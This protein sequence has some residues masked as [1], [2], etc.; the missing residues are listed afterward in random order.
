[1]AII[2]TVNESLFLHAFELAG[3]YDQMGG[4]AGLVAMFE[5][6]DSLSDDMGKNIELDPVAICCDYCTYTDRAE[7]ASD[8]GVEDP[9]DLDERTTVIEYEGG[10]IVQAF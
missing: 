6:L 10:I 8:Y 4:R 2:Q 3:R 5:H 1:M 7:A 9:E